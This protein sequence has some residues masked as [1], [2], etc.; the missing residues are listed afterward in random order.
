MN[1]FDTTVLAIIA[2][3]RD[4]RLPRSRW[5]EDQKVVICDADYSNAK[6]LSLRG[7]PCPLS[8]GVFVPDTRL[9][10]GTDEAQVNGVAQGKTKN[11]PP[12]ILID[13]DLFENDV[14]EET[15]NV[16][17]DCASSQCEILMVEKVGG[18]GRIDVHCMKEIVNVAE[19]RWKDWSWTLENA[20]GSAG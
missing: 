4:V 9:Q 20:L 12:T 15:G 18:A 8:F 7:L 19:Q 3:L 1:L 14:C 2:A 6:R 5:D 10:R 11:A 16:V 13:I 17:V